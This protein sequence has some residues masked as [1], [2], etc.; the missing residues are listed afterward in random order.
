MRV[1]FALVGRCGKLSCH[2]GDVKVGVIG[3]CVTSSTPAEQAYRL[4]DRN[5]TTLIGPAISKALPSFQATSHRTQSHAHVFVEMKEN[6]ASIR[7]ATVIDGNGWVCHKINIMKRN[8]LSWTLRAVR[9]AYWAY[10]TASSLALHCSSVFTFSAV[11]HVT[12]TLGRTDVLCCV[13]NAA[14][15]NGSLTILTSDFSLRLVTSISARPR[16]ARQHVTSCPGREVTT[17]SRPWCPCS[18]AR[19]ASRR[20]RSP[21]A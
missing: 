16:L 2:H 4:P 15:S 11:F 1:S 13:V 17:G 10:G 21:A 12:I 18:I 20:M 6:F 14:L 3:L 9:T 5:T 8:P 19:V 7:K